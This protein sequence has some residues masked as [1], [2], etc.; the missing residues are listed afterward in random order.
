MQLK[1]FTRVGQGLGVYGIQGTYKLGIRFVSGNM[2]IQFITCFIT[3]N[4]G[5]KV[6]DV[7]FSQ[8]WVYGGHFGVY[9]FFVY[10]G[11]TLNSLADPALYN[12]RK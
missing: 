10:I 5:Y 9:V 11:V 12:E 3:T 8:F 2:G 1:Y 4:F 7:P 6:Y